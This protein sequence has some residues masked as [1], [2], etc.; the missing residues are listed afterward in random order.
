MWNQWDTIFDPVM[1]ADPLHA[2]TGDPY[3]ESKS[4]CLLILKN[5]SPLCCLLSKL[6]SWCVTT[7]HQVSTIAVLPT[8]CLQHVLI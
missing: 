6:K 2:V 1:V 5:L 7:I 8:F 3:Q 4:Q